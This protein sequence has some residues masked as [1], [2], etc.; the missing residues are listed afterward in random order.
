MPENSSKTLLLWL[1]IFKTSQAP[2]GRKEG[3][4]LRRTISHRKALLCQQKKWAFFWTFPFLERWIWNLDQRKTLA[5]VKKVDIRLSFGNGVHREL[6]R[7]RDE[8][9]WQ[10]VSSAKHAMPFAWPEKEKCLKSDGQEIS[11]IEW[12]ELKNR[13]NFRYF[14]SIYSF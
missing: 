7:S 13:C 9:G 2:P 4:I 1:H 5:L 3:W 10:Y 6:N 14:L 12:Q 11:S 8:Q